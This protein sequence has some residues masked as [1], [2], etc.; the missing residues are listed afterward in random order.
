MVAGPKRG[1][2]AGVDMPIDSHAARGV[3]DDDLA[4]DH[5]REDRPGRQSVA[6][7]RSSAS[8]TGLA[9][10]TMPDCRPSVSGA[11]RMPPLDSAGLSPVIW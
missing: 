4:I 1:I 10:A 11:R 8:T 6:N 9:A 3:I 2:G 7:S 5:A